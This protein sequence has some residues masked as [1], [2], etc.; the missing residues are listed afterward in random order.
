MPPRFADLLF[1][2][3]YTL[4]DSSAGAIDCA[5]HALRQLG[6]PPASAAQIRRTIGLSLP[7]TL[8]QLAGDARAEQADA[9]SRLFIERA[10]QV[11]VD[12]TS[13]L[14]GIL[15]ALAELS[16][17]GARLGIV[18]TKYRRRIESILQ[19]DGLLD[20]FSVIVGGEDVSVHKPDPGGLLTAVEKLGAAPE[21]A[22]YVGDS[23]TDAE[24]ARRAGTPFAG[25]LTG[26]TPTSAF[27]PYHPLGLFADLSA[28]ATWLLNG[29]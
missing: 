25:V 5:N 10:E 7:A 8:S 3:D 1:D 14:P 6:L 26:V 4:V 9:F 16:Q 12:R 22:L 18:S 15:P 11:M 29:D 20:L 27:A 24:T 2:F 19:R 13:L 17:A 28:L 23:P 21:N